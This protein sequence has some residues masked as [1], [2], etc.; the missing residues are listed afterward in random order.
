MPAEPSAGHRQQPQDLAGRGTG[1]GAPADGDE[2]AGS[3]AGAP[4]APDP[5]A[6]GPVRRRRGPRRAT[7][8]T[9]AGAE[10]RLAGLDAP[11]PV[12]EEDRERDRDG[13][14]REEWLR[15]Q[16]PPHWD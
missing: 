10:P 4:A 16:R 7:G 15:A 14:A 9:A 1:P 3:A 6:G 12:P 5:G 13:H 2:A 11:P 8:G